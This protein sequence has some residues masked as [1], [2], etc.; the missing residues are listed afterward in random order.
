MEALVQP[1]DPSL[2]ESIGMIRYPVIV[3]NAVVRV[4]LNGYLSCG[5]HLRPAQ[6][7]IAF[8]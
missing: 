8:R 4:D 7:I 2:N 3:F 1:L 5:M 6:T